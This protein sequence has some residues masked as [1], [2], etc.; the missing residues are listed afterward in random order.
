MGIDWKG[1]GRRRERKGGCMRSRRGWKWAL[2]VVAATVALTVALPGSALALGGS[3]NNKDMGASWVVPTTPMTNTV[4]KNGKEYKVVT[5]WAMAWSTSGPDFLGINN[6]SFYGNGG[7]GNANVTNTTIGSTQTLLGIWASEANEVPNTFNWNSFYNL[8][9]DEQTAAGNAM[10]KTDMACT[11]NSP[12]WDTTAGVWGPFKYR[13]E[14]IWLCNNLNATQTAQYV[15]YINNGQY[16]TNLTKTEISVDEYNA[17]PDEEKA[18]YTA[19]NPRN[20]TKYTKTETTMSENKDS[21]GASEFYIEGDETYAPKVMQ[22]VSTNPYT[23][24]ES[25]YVLAG[26]ADQVIAETASMPGLAENEQLNWKTMNKLPRSTRY[27]ES[28]DECAMNIER[29]ARGSVYYTL[30]K[31]ADGTVARKKVAFVGSIP[32]DTDATHVTTVVYDY[33]ED[34]AG[35]ISANSTSY[36]LGGRASW[37]PL[38]VDQ[39]GQDGS[40]DLVADGDH[41]LTNGGAAGDPDLITVQQ[42]AMTRTVY[43]A[44][45]DDLAGCDVV[46]AANQNYT[47]QQW[48]DFIKTN[49]TSN[50]AKEAADTVQIVAGTPYVCNGSNYTMDKLIY[51]A[52]AMDCLYPELFPNMENSTFWYNKVYHI[53]AAMLGSAMTWAFGQAT[54]PAGAEL[55]SIGSSYSADATI[56]KYDTGLA[57]FQA[58]STTDPTLVRVLS[59]TGIDGS[60]S[61]GGTAYNYANF[62][63]STFWIQNATSQIVNPPVVE[64]ASQT[65]TGP[66]AS[67]AKKTTDKAFSLGAKAKTKLSFSSSNKSVATVD[68]SGKVTIKGAGTAKITIKAAATDQYKAASKTVTVKVTKAANTMTAKAKAKAVTVKAGKSV[69]ASKAIAVSK[70]KGKVSYAKAGKG[71]AK[72]TVANGKIAVKKGL[73]KGTYQIKVKVTAAGNAKFAKGAKTVTIKVKVN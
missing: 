65:I 16:V 14:I 60:T 33:T 72:I 50:E 27:A 61:V 64:P 20:P 48:R 3:S 55:S 73:K 42:P 51:G 54:L 26:Y 15:G 40:L 71:N 32:N 43:L 47:V 6:S 12:E 62:A 66:K 69:A 8:Y 37:S 52:F 45:A 57:Y 2:A 39:L 70:A 5:T 34:I 68:A 4:E 7:N 38:V 21:E 58:N 53:K 59:S 29:I 1:A 31:I 11:A 19:D 41:L 28:A 36:G 13:P 25:A 17:L 23:F 24:V 9:A 49:A 67:Y 63:P 18:G 44:T 35:G 10:A 46:Y 30:A 22:P 56:A